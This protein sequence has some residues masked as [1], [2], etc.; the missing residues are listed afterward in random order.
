MLNKST[1]ANF[2][3]ELG[4]VIDKAITDAAKDAAED[5]Q[6]GNALAKKLSEVEDKIAG[7][8]LQLNTHKTAPE[9]QTSITI[10]TNQ[11]AALS[12]RVTALETP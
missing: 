6:W 11:I 9:I 10:L 5:N 4:T 2:Q 12:A 8:K 3:A 7:L 1:W